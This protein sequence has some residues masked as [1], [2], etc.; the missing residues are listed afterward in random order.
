MRARS[1]ITRMFE[2]AGFTLVRKRN[3]LIWRCPCGHTQVT[4]AATPGKGRST[5]NTR[6][7]MN[8]TIR[9]CIPQQQRSAA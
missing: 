4:C 3:H 7:C 6:A 9:A 5:D 1:E 8:R 2:R